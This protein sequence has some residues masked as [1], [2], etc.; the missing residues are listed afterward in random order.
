MKVSCAELPAI[1]QK[2]AQE[3]IVFCDGTFDLLHPAHIEHLKTI[4][5]FGDLLVVGVMTD[6]W[7]KMRK[8]NTR[9]VL[10]Q[11][12]RLEMVDAIRYVDYSFLLYDETTKSRVRT[13]EALR[14]LRPNLFITTD[15]GW[16]KHH[17]ELT[18]LGVEIKVVPPTPASINISTTTLIQRILNLQS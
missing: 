18:P 8:G 17:D 12:D 4:R 7:V 5:Q 2:H 14:C 3:K 9:P 16:N 10:S 6:E 11:S 1:R 15:P 13:S